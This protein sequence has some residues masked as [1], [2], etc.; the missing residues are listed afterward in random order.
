M[1]THEGTGHRLRPRARLVLRTSVEKAT[2]PYNH[3]TEVAIRAFGNTPPT[4]RNHEVW[5]G[6]RRIETYIHAGLC[7]KM[8][9]LCCFVTVARVCEHQELRRSNLMRLKR[10][11]ELFQ[12]P[13]IR[14][15]PSVG[16]LV[17]LRDGSLRQRDRRPKTRGVGG[18][19]PFAKSYGS[20]NDQRLRRALGCRCLLIEYI[21]CGRSG[22]HSPP[23]SNV[24]VESI[25]SED[26][27]LSLKR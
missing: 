20:T 2:Q 9:E 21:P 10:Y 26:T 18:M 6:S 17:Q 12:A 22:D 1:M 5:R 19:P 15:L 7:V 14:E 3:P 13:N 4:R 8:C 27:V 16:D 11:L 24:S 25:P 23:S